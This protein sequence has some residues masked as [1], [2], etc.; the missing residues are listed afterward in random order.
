M[1]D[2]IFVMICTVLLAVIGYLIYLTCD[3]Y[4]D[5]RKN[6]RFIEENTC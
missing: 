3:A 5:R 1:I 2:P 4:N 6:K